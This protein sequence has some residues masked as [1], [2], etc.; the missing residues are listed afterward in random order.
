M[1]NFIKNLFHREKYTLE[2]G[3]TVRDDDN[4]YEII[5]IRGQYAVIRDLYHHSVHDEEVKRFDELY[6]LHK[7]HPVEVIS[8]YS[9][10]K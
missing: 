5:E 6:L 3:D 1:W 8:T 9:K 7:K 10:P 4:F 2:V